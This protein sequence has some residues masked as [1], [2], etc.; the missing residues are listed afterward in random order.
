MTKRDKIKDMVERIREHIENAEGE[1]DVTDQHF[2]IK[3]RDGQVVYIDEYDIPNRLCLNISKISYIAANF[4]DDSWDTEG[5]SW[6]KDFAHGHF[7]QFK[8]LVF[9]PSENPDSLEQWDKY[10]SDILGK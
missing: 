7:E 8:G 6:F 1:Y 5:K 10:V 9:D 4:P 2:I 3:Y